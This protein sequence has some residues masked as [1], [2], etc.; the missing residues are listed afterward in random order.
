MFKALLTRWMSQWLIGVGSGLI[1]AALIG[2][3]TSG[4]PVLI[5]FSTVVGFTLQALS[6]VLAKLRVNPRPIGRGYKREPRSG[7]ILV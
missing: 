1:T 2:F 7:S 6:L 3:V 4:P 5:A